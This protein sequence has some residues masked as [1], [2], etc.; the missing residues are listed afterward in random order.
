MAVEKS[1]NP[2]EV[3]GKGLRTLCRWSLWGLWAAENQRSQ[4]V[5]FQKP[6]TF[7]LL[8]V[9]WFWISGFGSLKLSKFK[10]CFSLNPKT[11]VTLP[12]KAKDN[13]KFSP[14]ALRLIACSLLTPSVFSDF[15]TI[16]L[17]G[18]HCFSWWW[19]LHVSIGFRQFRVCLKLGYALK[20]VT[21][22]FFP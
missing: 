10:K 18:S 2:M 3:Y 17:P 14:L 16:Y 21:L 20:N 4:L 1:G 22:I 11:D 15:P 6:V 5:R 8:L 13:S 19:I 9:F 7:G 12:W